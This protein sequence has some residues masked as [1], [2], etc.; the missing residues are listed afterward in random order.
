MLA[1]VRTA[2]LAAFFGAYSGSYGLER[3]CREANGRVQAAEASDAA[4]ACQALADA[5]RFLQAQ[6]LD[7]KAKVEVD[8]V[9][10]LTD[11][12]G[13]PAAGAY[14][15][16]EGRV[17]VL[18]YAAFRR[19]GTWLTLPI[20]PAVYRSLLVHEA[21]HAISARNFSVARPSTEA[22]EYIAYAAMFATMPP[23][24][25]QRVL[26]GF[27]SEG[28]QDD[29]EINSV[30][31]FFDHARFGVLAYRHFSKPEHGARY[32][33]AILAGEALVRE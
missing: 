24:Q 21:A 29:M 22:R 6:G 16:E 19:R 7:V 23:E 25:R 28:V 9:E 31:Y 2:V 11:L 3:S 14:I 13:V 10:S 17:Y 27:P 32:L 8:V 4:L 1:G 15:E 12:V 20:D 5:E 33:K 26:A 18:S 30:T